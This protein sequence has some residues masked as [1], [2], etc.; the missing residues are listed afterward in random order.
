VNA[1]TTESPFAQV[2][3]LWTER[4]SVARGRVRGLSSDLRRELELRPVQTLALAAA[5]GFLLGGGLF[6]RLTLR[7]LSFGTR[8]AIVGTIAS[9]LA[10][11]SSASTRSIEDAT[12]RARGRSIKKLLASET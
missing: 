2:V 3:S 7:A 1:K 8:V 12:P 11:V 10:N 9:D 4:A 6:S 5:A